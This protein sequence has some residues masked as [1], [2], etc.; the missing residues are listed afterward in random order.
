MGH[1]G[2]ALP[3]IAY[4]RIKVIPR[5]LRAIRR[6]HMVQP[7]QRVAVAVSGGADSVCLLHVLL[8]LAPQLDLHL[9]VLHLNH[10]LRGA[11]SRADA[12]FV[13]EV[14][15]SLNLPFTLREANLPSSGNL[16]QVARGARL[17]FFREILETGVA[18]R[19][20]VGHTRSDQAETVLYRFLR[21][22]GTTGLAAIRPV[23]E[24]GIIR[25]LL[26]CDRAEVEQYLCSRNLLWRSDS[27]NADPRFDRNRIRHQLLPALTREWNPSLTTTLAQTAEI[28]CAEEQYW[29]AEIARL[30]SA[31]IR[32]TANG[33]I[34]TISPLLDL[35]LAARRRV[36]RYAL[37][38]A[39]G[40]LRGIDF[41]H[42]EAVLEL[43]ASPKGH[44]R[45]QV[46]G[47]QV[48]RSFDWLR[49]TPPS[50]AA[51]PYHA[52]IE[53]PGTLSLP[54][55][56][57]HLS[58]ELVET[59]GNSSNSGYVYNGEVA[60][61]DRAR[62]SGTLV[63]RSWKP[64]DRY[65]P[66]AAVSVK[67]VKTLFQEARIPLW[68]RRN[69]PVI[70]DGDFIVWARRFGAAAQVAPGPHTGTILKIQELKAS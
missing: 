43:A 14:A 63:C 10:N 35:P 9:S 42:V 26:D 30:V 39:R 3:A 23:V 50:P 25:P 44:G 46:P 53:V 24:P 6:Y 22:S 37:Q 38:E 28:A 47:L 62:L 12:E 59:L 20:A 41:P 31:C 60:C 57:V 21:G 40:D 45:V 68:E 7:G 27:T 69:W 1:A 66:I 64:G 52:T 32:L 65:Q 29:S 61:L 58:L 11:E 5:V 8:E 2:F 49:L 15:A 16:E 51:E 19:V 18:A 34:V 56:N 67:K 33:L 48:L 36:V 17:A 13:R 55:P 54:G 70:L 4:D